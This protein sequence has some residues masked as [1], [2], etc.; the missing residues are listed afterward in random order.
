M[1]IQVQLAFSLSEKNGENAEEKLWNQQAQ[2]YRA[3][4]SVRLYRKMFLKK[5]THSKFYRETNP[6]MELL[7]CLR[8][9][10][11]DVD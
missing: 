3:S 11:L 7:Q 4:Y 5:N 10:Q 6:Y 9:S 8:E 1:V 2:L